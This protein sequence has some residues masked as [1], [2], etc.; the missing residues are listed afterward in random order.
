[1]SEKY[2]HTILLVDD[3]LPITNSLQRVFRKKDYQIF[4][5]DSGQKG[6]ELLNNEKKPFSLIIS[7]QKMPGMTGTEFLEKAKGISPQTIRV[8]LTSHADINAVIDAIN[9]GEIHRYITKPWD[10]NDLLMQVQQLLAQFEMVK[11]NK[12]LQDLTKK[13]NIKLRDINK[14]L[15]QKV[16]ER[17][18]EIMKKNKELELSLYNSVKA[19]AALLEVNDPQ[20]AV[21]GRRVSFLARHTAQLMGLPPEEVDQIEMAG[22]LHDIGKLGFPQNLLEYEDYRWTER[23]IAMFRNHPL[24]GQQSIQF[25]SRLKKVGN[26]IKCHHEQYDGQGY[27]DQLADV[28]IPLGARIIAVVDTYDNIVNKR[29][30]LK[31]LKK[32]QK[33][34]ELT[35]EHLSEDEVLQKA[36]ILEI[37]QNAFVKFDPDVVKVFFELLKSKDASFGRQKKVSVENL[38]EGMV[39]AKTLY[40]SSGRFLLP[41]NVLLKKEYILKLQKFHET[42]PIAD[43]IWVTT[44]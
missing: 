8:L 6:I 28:E 9:K 38:E 12:R 41:F 20:L 3:E 31:S 14:N 23:E 42:D 17:S 34:M 29:V 18:R 4:T 16:E 25:I 5:A 26:F 30:N 1:M 2:I 36:A 10:D 27:P 43:K 35:T 7:D 32:L 19:F 39:L 11:E 37:R 33:N 24:G 15:E 40:S 22:L 21:H 13:L 44:D